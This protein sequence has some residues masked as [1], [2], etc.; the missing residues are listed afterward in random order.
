MIHQ[1]QLSVQDEESSALNELMGKYIVKPDLWHDFNLILSHVEAYMPAYNE[2]SDDILQDRTVI[3][4]ADGNFTINTPYKA[5][6]LIMQSF[7]R[8]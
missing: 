7:C 5:F 3:Y 6:H 8:K 4:L 1:T 2:T